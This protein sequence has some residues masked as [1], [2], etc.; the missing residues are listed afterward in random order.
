VSDTASTACPPSRALVTRIAPSKVN[1]IALDSRLK[2]TF[3]HIPRSTCTGSSDG[4]QS[5]SKA[6]PARSI[7]ARKTLA[8]SAVNVPRSTGS[9]RACIRPASMREKSS[10]LFTS[11][12]SRSA[13]RWMTSTSS[14]TRSPASARASRSSAAGPRIRVS[15]VRNSW[16]T[17]AKNVVFAA[18]SSA[19][20]SARC[21]WAW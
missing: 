19:S 2:T 8:S 21:C 14:R 15:G 3:S 20:S 9:K 7:A 13:L 17:L 12:P 1:L 16:L 4:T 5:T 11:R 18:S 6:S 10:R